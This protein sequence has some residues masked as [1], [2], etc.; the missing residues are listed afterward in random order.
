VSSRRLRLGGDLPREEGGYRRTQPE[1]GTWAPSVK[2]SEV[3]IALRW[4][5]EVK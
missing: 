1:A 4:E 5:I 3:K 2:A